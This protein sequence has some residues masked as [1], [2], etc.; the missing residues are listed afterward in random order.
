VRFDL[1]MQDGSGCFEASEF[2]AFRSVLEQGG[3]IQ[4]LRAPGAAGLSRK[5]IDALTATATQAGAGGLAWFRLEADGK[6]GGG[7]ARFLRDAEVTQVRALTGAAAGDAVFAVAAAATTAAQA[8]GA[9]R[10]HLADLLG[11]PRRE[12]LHFLWVHRFPIFEP[13]ETPTGWGPSHHMFTMP[14]PESVS[15]IES[16]PGAVYGQLYDLVCNGVELGSG[17]IRIHEPE[18]QRRVMRQIGLSEEEL[19]RKFGFL[20]QAFEYG[21]PPHGGIAL[22][23]DRLVMLLVGGTSLRDVIAF[24]KTQRATSPMDGSPSE[25]SPAQLL[26]LGLQVREA[27]GAPESPEPGSA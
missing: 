22:G 3:K 24:P 25:L 18:L 16:D 26:E 27:E 10:L 13:A 9:A 5:Q 15:L 14:E 12:G 1:E 2:K 4:L 23:L 11:L 17:S 7:I 19:E 8:L 21:A 20:I 6:P